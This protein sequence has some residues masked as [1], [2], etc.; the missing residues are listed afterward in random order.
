VGRYGDGG[1]RRAQER[2]KVADGQTISGGLNETG[3][4]RQRMGENGKTMVRTFH[5]PP[6]KMAEFTDDG[7]L[8]VYASKVPKEALRAFLTWLLEN[9]PDEARPLAFDEVETDAA[10]GE[11][12]R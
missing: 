1:V 7:G 11:V 5:G 12:R 9:A 3:R 6:V 10:A 8:Y 4:R 2:D